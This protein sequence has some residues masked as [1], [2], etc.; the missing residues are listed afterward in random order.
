MALM[1]ER[2]Q[3]RKRVRTAGCWYDVINFRRARRPA[4]RET[5][6]AE[7]FAREYVCA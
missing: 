7:R 5:S 3:V 4:V 2:L 1:A 6:P